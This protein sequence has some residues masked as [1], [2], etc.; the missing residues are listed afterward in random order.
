MTPVDLMGWWLFL[1]TTKAHSEKLLLLIEF[2]SM[3][4]KEKSGF[5]PKFFIIGFDL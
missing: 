2:R 3:C 5:F 1:T 4:H